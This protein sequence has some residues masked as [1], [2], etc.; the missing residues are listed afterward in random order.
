MHFIYKGGCGVQEC[1]RI[2][3]FKEELAWVIDKR[4]QGFSSTMLYKTF[5]PLRIYRIKLF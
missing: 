4:L 5:I 3:V 1:T 2:K